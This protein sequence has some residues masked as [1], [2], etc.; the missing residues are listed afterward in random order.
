M[1]VEREFQRGWIG[2]GGGGGGFRMRREM[3]EIYTDRFRAFRV[4]AFREIDGCDFVC[5][6]YV[7]MWVVKIEPSRFKALKLKFKLTW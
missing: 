2:R 7:T 3:E 1:L 6:L 4:L 5:Y